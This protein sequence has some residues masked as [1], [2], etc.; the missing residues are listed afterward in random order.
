MSRKN[1]S[2][3]VTS[4][5]SECGVIERWQLGARD[6]ALV[7]EEGVWLDAQDVVRVVTEDVGKRTELDL[8]ELRLRED[9]GFAVKETIA[10][11]HSLESEAKDAVEGGSEERVGKAVLG[12]SSDPQIESL[13]RS[14]QLKE[15]NECELVFKV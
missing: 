12:Q 2:T 5:F 10:V 13:Q 8:P 7:G 11:S 6:A 15:T 14:V 3:E 9:T 4:V 1:A